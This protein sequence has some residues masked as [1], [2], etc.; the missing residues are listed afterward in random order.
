MSL[1]TFHILFIFAS[2]L[3]ALGF[4][5]WCLN[6]AGDGHTGWALVGWLSFGSVV[7][8]LAYGV[9]FLKKLKNVSFL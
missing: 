3:L 5:F 7:G 4:G 8:L 2:M 9:W 6:Q 1:K